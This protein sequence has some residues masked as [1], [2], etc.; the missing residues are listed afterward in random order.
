M[1]DFKTQVEDLHINVHS[2]EWWMERFTRIANMYSKK[3][4]EVFSTRDKILKQQLVF[5]G[6][7]VRDQDGPRWKQ[8]DK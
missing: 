2:V 3:Y 8:E 1:S 4:F 7:G 6:S 5:V